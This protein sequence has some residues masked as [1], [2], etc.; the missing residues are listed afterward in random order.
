ME[1]NT[2]LMKVL[3]GSHRPNFRTLIILEVAK[4]I[5]ALG[6]FILFLARLRTAN[7]TVPLVAFLFM[8]IL[9]TFSPA[10]ETAAQIK[11]RMLFDFFRLAEAT[12]DD[13]YR[14]VL[15]LDWAVKALTSLPTTLALVTILFVQLGLRSVPWI[16]AMQ[17]VALT[18]FLVTHTGRRVSPSPGSVVLTL[19]GKLILAVTAYGMF[20]FITFVIFTSRKDA[21]TYGLTLTYVSTLNAQLTSYLRK[22]DPL[23][24]SLQHWITSGHVMLG[25]LAILLLGSIANAVAL[26]LT[27]DPNVPNHGWQ[28]WS[29]LISNIRHTPS[30]DACAAKDSYLLARLAQANSGSPLNVI[31]P[32]ELLLGVGVNAALLPSIHTAYPKM[33]LFLI[34]GYMVQSGVVRTIAYYF[35]LVFR[36]EDDVRHIDLYTLAALPADRVAWGKIFLLKELSKRL[37]LFPLVVLLSDFA[38]YL[39]FGAVLLIPVVAMLW[40]GLSW[41]VPMIIKVD[42]HV[43]SMLYVMRQ[44]M[45][46]QSIR[47]FSGYHLIS[48]SDNAIQ[49]GF[50]LLSTLALLGASLSGFVHGI[51]WLLV[52][53]VYFAGL[54]IVVLVS[55]R[56]IVSSHRSSKGFSGHW[57]AEGAAVERSNLE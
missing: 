24:S 13:F 31:L 29:H 52:G 44:Q 27:R 40:I 25:L 28:F 2:F 30:V 14:R 56:I 8:Y 57:V 6:M 38:A 22:I 35:S 50:T 26:R 34:E 55:S 41:L 32:G 45:P 5:G 9:T 42:Y 21:E 12:D 53:A 43:F 54:A 4:F 33:L 48:S 11:Q 36:F 15:R 3:L 7:A 1:R 49:R 20:R 10:L 19:I 18:I 46:I 17:V 51:Q 23:N 39:R 16:L 47:D 37:S